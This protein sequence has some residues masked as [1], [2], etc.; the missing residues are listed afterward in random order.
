[1]AKCHHCNTYYWNLKPCKLCRNDDYKYC[2]SCMRKK[3]LSHPFVH[4]ERLSICTYPPRYEENLFWYEKQLRYSIDVCLKC[5]HDYSEVPAH[6]TDMDKCFRDA[7]LVDILAQEVIFRH[8]MAVVYEVRYGDGYSKDGGSVFYVL[9]DLVKR[10]KLYDFEICF[11]ITLEHALQK[12]DASHDVSKQEFV[13]IGEKANASLDADILNTIFSFYDT[14][15]SETQLDKLSGKL[16]SSNKWYSLNRLVGD[17]SK[18]YKNN[19]LAGFLSTCS[20]NE[21]AVFVYGDSKSRKT[22]DITMSKDILERYNRFKSSKDAITRAIVVA[23]NGNRSLHIS[24][25]R[26]IHVAS[27]KNRHYKIASIVRRRSSGTMF[28]TVVL[29]KEKNRYHLTYG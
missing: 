11:F 3:F 26:Y 6:D 7:K 4:D 10:A 21:T 2:S 8:E 25:Q 29:K 17:T 24:S 9:S 13:K 15:L 22:N 14:S 1:M 27:S 16:F 28:P 12:G 20:R 19:A 18:Q 5:Y 23:P